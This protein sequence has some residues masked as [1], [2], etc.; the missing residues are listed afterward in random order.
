LRQ[1]QKMEA[2]GQ[3]T[4][5]IAHD[6][7][8]LLTG[9]IGSIDIA[10]RRMAAS[11]PDEVPRFLDAASSAAHRAA[12]LT[13]RLLAF[14]RRQSLDT[15]RTD[16][17]KLVA[18]MEDMLR[19]TLGKEVGLYVALANGLWPAM[20]DAN[21]LE[22]A[23][24]NLAI[25]ARDAMP[26]GGRLTIETA[27]TH[28][29]ENYARQQDEVSAGDYV[30]ISVSDTGTGMS[31]EV[32]AQAFEPFFT[33]KPTG[34][35]TGLGLS[36]IYGFVKQ[37][38][39]HVHIYSEVGSGTTIRLYLPRALTDTGTLAAM[40]MLSTPQGEGETILV[41]EDDAAVRLLIKSVLEEL[42]YRYMDA[43]DATTALAIL[44]TKVTIDLL[45]TDVGLPVTNGRQLAEIAQHSRPNLRVL[46]VTGYAE[47]ATVRG[48]FL[49]AGMDMLTK[50]FALDTLGSK[51]REMI[52]R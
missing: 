2:I 17:N 43:P 1:S 34:V 48:G 51:V 47:A 46:F 9:I 37:S 19:R 27:N 21:Q 26:D 45:I 6:F 38:H 10:R 41:V 8:N 16:V 23:V 33:T 49:A 11:R 15:A 52:E 22:N 31:P 13:N 30:A 14:A 40:E 44:Q 29:D 7:N 18:D 36:M 50:P 32:I 25:N 35:G 20:L 5:G 3:L 24:L 28:L 12:A 42:G 4:G 39:G